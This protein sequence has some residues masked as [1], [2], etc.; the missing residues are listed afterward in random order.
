MGTYYVS[1]IHNNLFL[2][3]IESSK[4]TMRTSPLS[5]QA[6]YIEIKVQYFHTVSEFRN[7]QYEKELSNS[8]QCRQKT[9]Q[10]CP[11]LWG[12]NKT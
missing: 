10:Q 4:G 5:G 1:L 3:C 9:I 12:Q 2:Y 6:R 7:I 8:V 11:L